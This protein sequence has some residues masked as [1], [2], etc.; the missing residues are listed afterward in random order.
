MDSRLKRTRTGYFYGASAYVLWGFFPLYWPYVKPASPFEILSHRIIWSII[1]CTLLL[2]FR[3][4][5]RSSFSLLRHLVTLKWLILSSIALSM[6]WVVFIWAVNNGHTIDS[7]MGYYICPL[8]L[9]TFGVL[10]YKERLSRW[11]WIAVGL[12]AISVIIL[13]IDYGALPWVSLTLAFSFGFYGLLK[14]HIDSAAL[15]TFN[16]ET[17]VIG[18]PALFYLL[19][20][21]HQGTG[22]FGHGTRETLMLASAGIVT[23]LPILLFN[24]ATT[25]LPLS[26]IG[27]LQY[28]NPSIQFLIGVFIRH[29][30]MSQAR[31]IC[32]GLIWSALAILAIDGLRSRSNRTVAGTFEY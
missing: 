17:L 23:T 25:R 24:G 2:A 5:L 26:I 21:G 9:V 30:R 29:E 3:K 12:G 19:Y 15:E 8:V 13:S 1:V 32:F 27:L 7:A 10:L 28:I 16:A 18:L 20:L 14:K 4:S 22:Q 31:W 6:N 11:Q